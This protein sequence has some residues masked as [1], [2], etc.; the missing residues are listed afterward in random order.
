[1]DEQQD[2]SQR[3]NSA[4]DLLSGYVA[5]VW[6][7]WRLKRKFQLLLMAAPMMAWGQ[8]PLHQTPPNKTTAL[9]PHAMCCTD[10]PPPIGASSSLSADDSDAGRATKDLDSCNIHEVTSLPGSH[11]FGSD[12]I[13]AMASDPNPKAKDRNVVWGLTADLSSEVPAQ[14]RAMYISKS[15]DGGRTWAQV[16]RMDSEYFD[17]DI[18]EGERNGLSVSPGG[19]DFVITTQRGAFQ[20]FPQSST[21]NALVKSILGPRVPQPDPEVSIPKREGDPVTANVVKITADGKHMIVGYGYFDLHPQIFTYHKGGDGSWIE[22]G[23]LPHLPTEM[24]ILSM[25]FD[26]PKGRGGSLLYVGTGDQAYWLNR[27]TMKWTR[28]AGVGADSAVQSI[29]TVGGP[30]LAACWGVYN[31]LSAYTV[32]RVTHAKFLLHRDEDQAGANI[33]AFGI[34]V[35]PSK[36]NREIVTSLTGVYASS[37]RGKSWKRLND[38]PDGEFRSAHFSDDGTVIVSGIAGTF[39]ANPFSKSCSAR[40]KTRIK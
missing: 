16:A 27:R 10:S 11:L 31:P 4:L 2:P 17:A 15:T 14:N 37:D 23:P 32:Q 38:L 29:S 24:D 5:M 13:E 6:D 36:P 22:D 18:G 33:R 19:T 9:N 3:R 25:Q 21:S 12:F 39:L 1:V 30:H 8:I 20:I 34:E 28:V 40:L 7:R 35:D 26:A